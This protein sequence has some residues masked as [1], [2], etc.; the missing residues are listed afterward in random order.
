MWGFVDKVGE[1]RKL[2]TKLGY[3]T[4]V[5]VDVGV[6]IVTHVVIVTTDSN[7]LLFHLVPLLIRSTSQIAVPRPLVAA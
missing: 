5:D 7:A 6:A 2:S 4:A 3:P 1:V